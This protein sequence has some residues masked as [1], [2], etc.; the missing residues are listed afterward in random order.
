MP[1]WLRRSLRTGLQIGVIEAFLRLLEAFAVPISPEQHTALLAFLTPIL[2][3]IQ[4]ALEDNTAFPALLKAPASSG[5]N[6]EP[7]PRGIP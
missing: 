3:A 1:D 4:N 7:T 2:A 5:Q 6:P